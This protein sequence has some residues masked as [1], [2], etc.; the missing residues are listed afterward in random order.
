MPDAVAC[1]VIGR[2]GLK[3]PSSQ[4]SGTSHDEPLFRAAPSAVDEGQLAAGRI[5]FIDDGKLACLCRL[6]RITLALKKDEHASVRHAATVEP[7]V[8]VVTG[9]P[10]R[11]TL[12]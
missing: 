10:A 6:F 9:H 2:G 3:V 4:A 7:L 5:S 1:F 8:S 11:F 12:R